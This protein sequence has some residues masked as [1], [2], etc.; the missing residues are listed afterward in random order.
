[1][2]SISQNRATYLGGLEGLE[3]TC[4]TLCRVGPMDFGRG[5]RLL[6]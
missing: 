4:Y 2:W 5:H 3:S 1:M 6:W